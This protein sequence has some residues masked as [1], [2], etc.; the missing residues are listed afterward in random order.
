[1][2]CPQT[3]RHASERWRVYLL[4]RR[5]P[6]APAGRDDPATGEQGGAPPAGPS[7]RLT[8]WSWV[9]CEPREP[10]PPRHFGGRRPLG[11]LWGWQL[12]LAGGPGSGWASVQAGCHLRQARVLLSVW[13][14]R[15]C[16][17]MEGTL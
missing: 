14:Q 7:V 9:R 3:P 16:H 1:M 6:D 13:F 8:R 12:L 4:A 17:I 11:W 5:S 2:F 15:T 10:D